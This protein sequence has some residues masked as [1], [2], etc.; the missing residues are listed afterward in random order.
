[1]CLHLILVTKLTMY[2]YVYNVTIAKPNP[3]SMFILREFV[4]KSMSNYFIFVPNWRRSPHTLRD[5]SKP[6]S[7]GIF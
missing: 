4:K 7:M 5:Y 2:C 3:V 6:S 1:M